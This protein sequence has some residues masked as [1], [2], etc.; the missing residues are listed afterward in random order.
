MCF[1]LAEATRTHRGVRVP[2][3]S[4]AALPRR[5]GPGHGGAGGPHADTV[6]SAAHGQAGPTAA[7]TA[8]GTT[9]FMTTGQSEDQ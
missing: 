8:R 4:G 5:Q 1:T 9:P 2:P 6:A 7:Q 3:A